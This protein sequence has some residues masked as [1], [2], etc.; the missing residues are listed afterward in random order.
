MTYLLSNGLNVLSIATTLFGAGG[1]VSIGN[2]GLA[3]DIIF[4]ILGIYG[5]ILSVFSTFPTLFDEVV[6]A[7]ELF[8]WGTEVKGFIDGYGCQN[9]YLD[10]TN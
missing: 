10:P 2:L 4:E 9:P 5:L 7:A 3:T 1:G 6:D 8:G